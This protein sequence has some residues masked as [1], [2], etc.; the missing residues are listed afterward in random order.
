VRVPEPLYYRLDHAGNYH[1]QWFDW[2]DERKRAS[3]TTMFTG[4][5]EAVLPVCSTAE[6]QLFFQ[7]F[8]LDRISVYRPGQSYHYAAQSPHESGVIIAECFERLSRE[9]HLD[10]WIVP[11]VLAGA[12]Q[13][14]PVDDRDR[15]DRERITR[16]RIASLLR[17]NESLAAEIRLLRRSRALAIARVVRRLL[18]LPYV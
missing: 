7:H 11:D 14:Q 9:G 17:E 13:R 12:A 2:P 4:W 10:R 6:E 8:I 15:T 16:D 18:G 1:K 5:L 3:W